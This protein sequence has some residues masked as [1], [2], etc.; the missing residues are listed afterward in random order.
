MA[1][2]YSPDLMQ[3]G[4]SAAQRV[5]SN[6]NLNDSADDS[7]ATGG[8]ELGNVFG[9]F[10]TV[11][12]YIGA[13]AATSRVFES[14]LWPQRSFSNFRLSQTPWR[15]LLRPMG[16]PMHKA[17]LKTFD[18][19]YGHDLFN[20]PNQGHMLGTAFFPELQWSY[21]MHGQGLDA[22]H[23]EPLRNCIWARAMSLVPMF[24]PNPKVGS[25]TG[26]EEAALKRPHGEGD[27]VRA[28][29]RVNHLTITKA[30][31]RDKQN[32]RTF[33]H[34]SP[35]GIE[36]R[37]VMA[38]FA[39]ELTAVATAVFVAT[40]FHTPWALVW[41]VPLI[42]RLIS[43]LLAVEREGLA[44]LTSSTPATDPHCDFEVHSPETQP[45]FLLMTGPPAIVLQFVRHYGHPK[46]NRFREVVQL[47]VVV[48]FACLFPL[49]LACSTIWMSV[50]VQNTWLCYQLYCVLAMHVTRYSRRGA[51]SDTAEALAEALSRDDYVYDDDSTSERCIL[52]GHTRSGDETLKIGLKSTY[53]RRYKQ[54]REALDYL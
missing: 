12:G 46:R 17:A 51:S 39:S 40:F 37:T 50:P 16:G 34:E 49:E 9:A 24:N 53:H 27:I 8:N 25:S 20:G 29:F 1:G 33:V 31:A 52:F 44:K 35:Q 21:T 47:S 14:L 54:G 22:G 45:N 6:Q 32:V 13:E 11:L 42:L 28:R 2:F 18:V 23:T 19:M 41:I 7:A 48:A 3:S 36:F 30:T 43:L 10:G 26:D 38:I 5:M 4:A 15:A